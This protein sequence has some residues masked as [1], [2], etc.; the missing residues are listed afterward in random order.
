MFLLGKLAS[1]H[2]PTN[3]DGS[4]PLSQQPLR[5]IGCFFASPDSVHHGGMMCGGGGGELGGIGPGDEVF[6]SMRFLASINRGG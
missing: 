6:C 4:E 5:Q 1:K 2:A 3:H